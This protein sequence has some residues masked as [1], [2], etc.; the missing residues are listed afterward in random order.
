DECVVEVNFRFAPDRSEQ[1]AEAYVRDFFDGFD[2]RVT[3]SAPGAVPGLDRA[4][5]KAFVDVVGREVHPKFG[6]T[7]VARFS[8]LGV[9][10]VNYGPGDPLFAH[11]KDEHVPVAEIISCEETLRAWLT[12][13]AAPAEGTSW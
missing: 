13:D 2:V 5:A 1:D 11:K 3:D 7:D 4:A 6:W 10:A 8:V 9:P 12:A